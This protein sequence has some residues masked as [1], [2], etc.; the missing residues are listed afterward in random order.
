MKHAFVDTNVILRFLVGDPPEMAEASTRLFE[1]VAEGSVDLVVDAVVIAEAVWV[2]GSFYGHDAASIAETLRAFLLQD[3]ILAD[4]R[5]VLLHALTLF[6][7]HG[8]DFVDA[9]IAARMQATGIADI[10][11]FDRHLDR[12][13]AVRR[14][15]PGDA[16]SLAVAEAE[17]R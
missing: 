6:E 3:G 2:L 7:T 9:L 16:P 14:H 11:S 10:F 13:P 8:V 1:A 5:D 17:P 12:L 4:D 15:G